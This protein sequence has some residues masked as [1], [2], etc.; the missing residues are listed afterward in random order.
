MTKLLLKLAKDKN[1]EFYGILSGITGICCNVILCIFKFI[2]GS[3]SGSISITADALNNLSDVASNTV[4][5]AGAKIS[6]KPV[7]KEH[8]F[9]HGRVEYISA[10]AVAGLIFVMGFELAKSSFEKIIHPTE[11]KFNWAFVIVLVGSILVKFWMAYFNGKLFKIT[12]NVSLKAVK[13]DS[14][15]DSISTGATVIALVVSSVFGIKWFDGAIGLAVAVIIF[16]SG[17]G[18][19]KDIIGPLLGQ[20]PDEQLVED[21]KNALME[22]DMIIGVHD[23]IVH[24]YGPGRIIA[25][26]HAEVPC[27]I[28]V[29]KIHEVIDDVEEEIMKRFNIIISIHM[30]PIAVDD[31]LVNKYKNHMEE[32]ISDYGDDY[33]F[34]DFRLVEKTEGGIILLDLVVPHDHEKTFEEIEKEVTDLYHIDYPDIDVKLK[35]EYSFV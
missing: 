21:L 16:A 32:I 19:I 4:T 15:N 22:P 6:S 25:S 3:L 33:S 10:L 11:L 8:P 12:N 20:A 31:E 13:Q 27:D 9:G 34:H 5:I 14:L 18:I 1:R 29:M 35:L 24:D 30:D 28:D 17:I 26:A 2:V 23:L 7:D